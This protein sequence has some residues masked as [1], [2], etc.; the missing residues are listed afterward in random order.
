MVDVQ[1]EARLVH[2]EGLGSL[3]VGHRYDNE[4]EPPFHWPLLSLD[5]R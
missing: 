4:L 3:D 5:P 2:V 1:F